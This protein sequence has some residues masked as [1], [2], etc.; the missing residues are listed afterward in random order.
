MH[1]LR[2]HERVQL[3]SKEKDLTKPAE[4]RA[5]LLHLLEFCFDAYIAAR[6]LERTLPGLVAALTDHYFVITRLELQRR[7]CVTH[8]RTVDLDVRAIRH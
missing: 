1:E 4:R 3:D 6:N 5:F 2:K 8:K 7:W